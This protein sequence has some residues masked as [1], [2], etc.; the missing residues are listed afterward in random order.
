MNL[1]TMIDHTDTNKRALAY[2]VPALQMEQ[3]SEWE[4]LLNRVGWPIL[5]LFAVGLVAWKVG[6]FLAPQIERI[7]NAQVAFIDGLKI[8]LDSIDGK[9]DRLHEK[10]DGERNGGKR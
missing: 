4:A 2:V 8:K 10:V 1:A 7:V 6:K 5:I 3:L 9:L